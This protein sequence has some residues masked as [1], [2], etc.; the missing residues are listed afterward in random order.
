[1]SHK[2]R[3]LRF[4]LTF[5]DRK[6]T[7]GVHFFPLPWDHPEIYPWCCVCVSRSFCCLVN[8]APLEG[9]LL[10][11][12][13]TA[14]WTWQQAQCLSRLGR[15][16]QMLI[17][18]VKSTLCWGWRNDSVIKNID[19]LQRTQ[20]L[21]PELTW[22]FTAT[23]NSRCSYRHLEDLMPFCV[24][25]GHQAWR[26]YTGIYVGKT[27]TQNSKIN[28]KIFLKLHFANIGVSTAIPTIVERLKIMQSISVHEL[29]PGHVENYILVMW[30]TVF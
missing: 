12:S 8:G 21:V 30:R 18:W 11:V 10:T 17:A 29:C 5:T 19:F 24:L 2:P 28:C 9:H 27:H 7:I 26:W 25:W 14:P 20:V 23:C 1:M 15:A 13:C 16:E 22:W 4:P 3:L 6:L